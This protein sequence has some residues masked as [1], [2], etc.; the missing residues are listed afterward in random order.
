MRDKINKGI[1][2][3]IIY[4]IIVALI[5]EIVNL[6][7]D[8]T[9]LI[10]EIIRVENGD[11][12]YRDYLSAIGL[13]S[14]Y[15]TVL[16][17]KIFKFN[18]IIAIAFYGLLQNI[19][20]SLLIYGLLKKTG[21]NYRAALLGG[22]ITA[23][24]FTPQIGG[25]YYDNIAVIIGLLGFYILLDRNGIFTNIK[26]KYLIS[27][28]LFSLALLTKQN[29]GGV[30]F[31]AAVITILFFKNYKNFII[32]LLGFIGATTLYLFISH[33]NGQ[34]D[35]FIYHAF[36]RISEYNKIEPRLSIERF[37]GV[38][39]RPYGINILDLFKLGYGQYLFLV[40]YLYYYAFTLLF[41]KIIYNNNPKNVTIFFIWLSLVGTTL[42]I[43]RGMLEIQYFIGFISIISAIKIFRN[44]YVLIFSSIYLIISGCLFFIITGGNWSINHNQ[45]FQ[46]RLYSRINQIKHN[47]TDIR[48]LIDLIG[49]N[50][51]V[52]M[53]GIGFT[54]S[55]FDMDNFMPTNY[56]NFWAPYVTQKK[57]SEWSSLESKNINT[58]KPDYVIIG[59]NYTEIISNESPLKIAIDKDYVL[60]DDNANFLV[61]K[62]L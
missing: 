55:L 24:W 39:L 51:K 14:T 28:M 48:R 29:S 53:I 56:I 16:P 32:F 9:V 22:F 57:Y 13:V 36:I 47:D 43:G 15:I 44:N 38:I 37:I 54:G 30:L 62:K 60:Y 18:S 12:V 2:L 26:F 25:I 20:A 21:V 19:I 61:F 52:S 58:H 31:I 33:I 49:S 6:Q 5:S 50:K 35:Q 27:G 23:T 34:M 41:I 46:D 1:Y 17:I 4:S 45:N 3:L 8:A 59:K 40:N 42:S 7:Y 11:I 10:K